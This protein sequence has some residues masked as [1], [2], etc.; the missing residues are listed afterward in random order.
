MG[1]SLDSGVQTLQSGRSK[2]MKL[3]GFQIKRTSKL[4]EP[5]NLKMDG[6]KIKQPSSLKVNGLNG[7]MDG[8]GSYRTVILSQ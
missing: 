3:D 7:K 1:S 4:T 6:L 5:I 8:D 2:G